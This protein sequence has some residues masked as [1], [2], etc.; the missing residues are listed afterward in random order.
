MLRAGLA[1]LVAA[2]LAAG[3]KT[4][5]V[6]ADEAARPAS[7]TPAA[8]ASTD[9][10]PEPTDAERSAWEACKARVAAVKEEPALPGAP[11]YEEQRVQFARVRGRPMLWRTVP[12]QTPPELASLRKKHDD[13]V[14]LVRAVKDV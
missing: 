6:S 3:C 7:A 12:G 1:L 10:K 2:A 13:Q 11:A 9:A 8:S 5:E 4:D 14:R